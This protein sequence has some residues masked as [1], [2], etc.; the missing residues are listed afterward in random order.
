MKKY[1]KS[2]YDPYASMLGYSDEEQ[3]QIYL[4][5]ARL[6]QEA[7]AN[8]P[9]VP[10]EITSFN[11]NR[12]NGVI[13]FIGDMTYEGD[14]RWLEIQVPVHED[15]QQCVFEFL[16]EVKEAYGMEPFENTDLYELA[17]SL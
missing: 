3:K 14:N 11:L 15:Y 1:V 12:D 4:W 7:E 8:L 16:R 9:Q 5:A 10:M 17:E 13:K 6:M 2:G